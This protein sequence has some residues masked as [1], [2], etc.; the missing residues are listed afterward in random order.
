MATKS[1]GTTFT[2][3]PAGGSAA[4]IGQLS[5]ISE[6][7]CDSELI[8]VTTLSEQSGCRRVYPGRARC[9][10][11]PPDGLP[12]GKPTR[13]RPPC[14]PPM[15]AARQARRASI[16]PDGAAYTFPALVKSCSLG[17]AQVDGA[18]GFGCVLR[19][20]GAVESVSA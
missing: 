7:N 3:T 4:K 1:L 14:A 6:L 19:V 17:A 2:F 20:N 10:R 18:I 9:G 5:A 16:F 13:A 15:K 11:N 12:P 8:D